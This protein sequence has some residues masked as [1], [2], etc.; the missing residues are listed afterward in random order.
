MYLSMID[1]ENYM[2]AAFSSN[3][4]PTAANLFAIGGNKWRTLRA[5][6]SPTFTS[7]KLKG[8]FQTLVD[9]SLLLEKYIKDHD[10]KEP[11]EIKNI[12]SK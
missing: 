2:E 10:N 4:F 1:E 11:I 5:K 12:L 3:I 7:G 8:M 6:V 9:C